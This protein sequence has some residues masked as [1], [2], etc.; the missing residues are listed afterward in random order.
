MMTLVLALFV[1]VGIG[2]LAI[3]AGGLDVAAAMAGEPFYFTMM[4][5]AIR[6]GAIDALIHSGVRNMELFC[7]ACNLTQGSDVPVKLPLSQE[8]L[9]IVKVGGRLNWIRMQKQ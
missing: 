3:G 1:A 9:D 8:E 6:R 5:E 7:G 4:L 2:M